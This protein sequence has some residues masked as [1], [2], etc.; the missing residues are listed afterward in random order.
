MINQTP[1]TAIDVIIAGGGLA[2]GLTALAL[3]ARRP[4]LRVMLIEAEDRVGGNHVWSH[5]GGDVAP[6]DRWLVAP[7]ISH[8]WATHRVAFPGHERV[9][10]ASYA[11]IESARLDAAVRAALPAERLLTGRH[12]AAVT[13]DSVTLSDGRVLAAPLVI[14]A[15]GPADLSTLDLGYQKFV[16]QTLDLAQPHGLDAPVIMDARVDQADGYRFVYVLP[17]SPTRVFV[18]DTYYTA[19]PSLDEGAIIGRIA[20]YARSQGWDAR[21][22]NHVERGVLPVVMNGDFDAYWQSGGAGI[23]KIGLRGA[24]FHCMTGYSLPDAVRVATMIAGLPDLTSAPVHDALHAAARAQ[25]RGQAFYRLLGKMLFRAAGPAERYRILERFYRLS[26]GLI[27]R[28]YAGTTTTADKIR[29]LSG[30]PPV[31]LTRAIAALGAHAS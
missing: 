22:T 3:V 25:W 8:A 5:F 28:F 26:P 10:P 20:D 17:L 15:R 18:E 29:I 30:R 31:P 24:F 1:D 7:L 12:V 2:G 4:A 21:P 11:S 6:E 13:P 9:L 23:P 16:G 19:G 14:D 27:D